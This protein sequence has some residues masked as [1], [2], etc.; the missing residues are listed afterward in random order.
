MPVHRVAILLL[1]G[2]L[3][4]DF[5]IPT[6]I[7]AERDITPYKTVLC[8]ESPRVLIHGGY[9]LEVPGTLAD[10]RKA[11]TVIV[12][13]FANHSRDFSAEVLAVL[14]SLHRRS[15]RVVSICTGAFALAQ[16]GVLD[17]RT[18]ATHWRDADELAR[19]Y[20]ALTVD[21]DALYV[22]EGDV[23]TSAGVASGIDLCLHIVRR[24]LGSA[25]ANQI[26][27]LIVSAPHREGGQS[28]F[29]ELPVGG[30]DGSL[31]TTRAWALKNLHK[32]LSI[33]DLARAAKVSERTLARR[34]LAETGSPPLQ[35][36]LAARIQLARELIEADRLGIDQIAE[37]CGLGTAA[38]L[39]MHFRRLVGTT[40]T[41]YRKAFVG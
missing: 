13:G 24:D 38:N 37:R 12:P 23:L 3:P 28:Q 33:K 1:D 27:R 4:L 7:F 19:R 6:Q 18:A 16:A 25:V 2:V 5:A 26:A 41:A 17:G 35:W 30:P 34:F 11:D 31:A 39:R 32:P 40:P 14:R 29:V 22:D 8:A 20:P 10:A 36:L 9:F 21:T 15:R